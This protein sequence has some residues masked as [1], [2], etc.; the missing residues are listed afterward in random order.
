MVWLYKDNDVGVK[1]DLQWEGHIQGSTTREPH[2]KGQKEIDVV[3]VTGDAVEDITENAKNII[4][5]LDE[6]AQG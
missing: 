3:D 5:H 6:V 2:D 1:G 4:D